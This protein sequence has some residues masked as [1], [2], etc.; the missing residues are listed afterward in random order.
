MS[1]QHSQ[2]SLLLVP[3]ELSQLKL[4]GETHRIAPAVAGR[5]QVLS[6]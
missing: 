3:S 6:T 2:R 5:V 1:H 4:L